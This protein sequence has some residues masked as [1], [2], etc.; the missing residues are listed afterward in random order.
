MIL[1]IDFFYI[2]NYLIA[3]AAKIFLIFTILVTTAFK[4]NSAILFFINFILL[5]IITPI[6][7]VHKKIPTKIIFKQED[8]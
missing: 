1:I 6:T 4:S 3:G 7:Y 2:F 5:D 8:R